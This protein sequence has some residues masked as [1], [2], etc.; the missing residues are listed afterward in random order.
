M[1]WFQAFAF[2]CSLYRY[3]AVRLIDVFEV[4]KVRPYT[5]H[6]VDP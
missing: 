4:D 2:K 3:A 6:P 1:S 5:L